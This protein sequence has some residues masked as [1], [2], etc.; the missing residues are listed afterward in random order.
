MPKVTKKAAKVA[1][2]PEKVKK[3]PLLADEDTS[4]NEEETVEETADEVVEDAEE[5]DVE[6]EAP[7]KPV[8]K[9]APVA[10]VAKVNIGNELLSDI[11]RTKKTLD[12]E[13]KIRFFVPLFE[14]EKAGSIHQCFI[15]GYMFS[16]KKGVMTDVPETVAALLADHYKITGEAGADF[17]LDLSSNK[18]DALG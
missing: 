11:A 9:A 3:N 2:K 4:E 18:Q 14:G 17:R 8:K 6:E 12:A 15:N 7:A 13:P 1:T 5:V 16:V 10:P